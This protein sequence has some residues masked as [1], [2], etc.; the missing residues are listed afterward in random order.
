MGSGNQGWAVPWDG[1][2]VADALNLLPRHYTCSHQPGLQEGLRVQGPGLTTK[3][4]F[5]HWH[6]G[7]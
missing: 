2:L 6:D 1:K 5:R 7:T 4:L 3:A